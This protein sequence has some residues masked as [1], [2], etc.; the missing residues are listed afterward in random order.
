MK[1]SAWR[2]CWKNF[3]EAIFLCL[4]KPFSSFPCKIF[5]II[6]HGIIRVENFPL[7]VSKSQSRITMC[8]LHWCYTFCTGVTI[9]ALLAAN[10][11]QE[12]FS[13]I[14]LDIKLVIQEGIQV[15]DEL[16]LKI[17]PSWTV[18]AIEEVLFLICQSL[19]NISFYF[20]SKT[21]RVTNM[22]CPKLNR[23]G[24]NTFL[25]NDSWRRCLYI[26]HVDQASVISHITCLYVHVPLTGL[27]KVGKCSAK[28][29]FFKVREKSGNFILSRKI[30]NVNKIWGKLK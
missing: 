21:Q 23:F 16:L 6:L 17:F 30:D 10:Q 20:S 27:P 14:L 13:C 7:S 12:F 1:K 5:V 24:W 15:A 26:V 19:S 2:K 18:L 25:N 11:N 9:F 22:A 4:R 29:I 8:N 3:H 28:K